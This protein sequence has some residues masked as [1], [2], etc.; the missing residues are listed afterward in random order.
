MSYTARHAKQTVDIKPKPRHK[1]ARKL[2]AILAVAVL[3]GLV[4]ALIISVTTTPGPPA[5]RHVATAPANNGTSADQPRM[6]ALPDITQPPTHAIEH[7]TVRA[8]D[9]L[10]VIAANHHMSNWHALYHANAT[11]VGSNPNLIFPG[12]VLVIP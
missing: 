3:V 12:Q 8:G 4:G 5:P 1:R 6:P 9:N 10:T 11:T 7:Y 2:T